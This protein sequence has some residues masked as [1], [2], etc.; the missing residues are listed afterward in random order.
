VVV[1]DAVEELQGEAARVGRTDQPPDP[2]FVAVGRRPLVQGESGRLEFGGAGLQCGGIGQLP[3]GERQLVRRLGASHVHS[4]R[5]VVDL[6]GEPVTVRDRPGAQQLGVATPLVEIG[7]PDGDVP[8]SPNVHGPSPCRI[9][10]RAS[11]SS[12]LRPR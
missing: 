5:P 3:A 2:T 11:A 1:H 4:E 9:P 10:I 8:Q 7:D 12:G 6:H